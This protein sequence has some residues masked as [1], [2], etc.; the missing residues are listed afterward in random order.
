MAFS[1]SVFFRLRAFPA[2]FGIDVCAFGRLQ[3][4]LFSRVVAKDNAQHP[5]GMCFFDCA[6]CAGRLCVCLCRCKRRHSGKAVFCRHSDS[7]SYNAAVCGRAC[8]HSAFWEAGIFYAQDFEAEYFFVWIFRA[9]NCAD[10]LF[11]P[12]GVSY[13]CADAEGN[14]RKSGKRRKRNGRK[15]AKDFF[16]DNTAVEPSGNYFFRIVCCRK[17]F[18]RFWKSADCGRT[19]SCP[20]GGNL[21][22]AYGL[23]ENRS[24]RGSWNRACCSE[25]CAVFFFRT[26]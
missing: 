1:C 20:C 3:V 21:Q 17:R 18:K 4:G 8:L 19:L 25:S 14:Q 2:F 26:E 16:Y 9:F 11:F 24:Q 22:S 15:R 12:D 5:F 10:A 13:L 6:F 7:A 23:A